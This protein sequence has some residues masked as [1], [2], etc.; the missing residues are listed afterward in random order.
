MYWYVPVS[1]ILPDPVQGVRIPDAVFDADDQGIACNRK[2]KRWLDEDINKM[3][4]DGEDN[5]EEGGDEE[6]NTIENIDVVEELPAIET[7]IQI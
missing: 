1:T 4:A 6:N 7:P 2:Q 3:E 5:T